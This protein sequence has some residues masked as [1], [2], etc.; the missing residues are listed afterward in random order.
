MPYCTYKATHIP[1]TNLAAGTP[2]DSVQHSQVYAH[3]FNL[4]CRLEPAAIYSL[5]L[6]FPAAGCNFLPYRMQLE[7]LRVTVG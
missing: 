3:R 5:A 2:N 7:C 4:F 1:V 6:L